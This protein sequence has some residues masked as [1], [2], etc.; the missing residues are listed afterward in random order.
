[1]TDSI[2][3][4]LV[5]SFGLLSVTLNQLETDL[6]LLSKPE[7]N[8]YPA[9]QARAAMGNKFHQFSAP[10]SILA[11]VVFEPDFPFYH[12]NEAIFERKWKDL[13]KIDSK[14]FQ[15]PVPSVI[16]VVCV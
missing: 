7:D 9:T 1:M 3:C 15:M 16:G 6:R 12:V 11:M 10:E 14:S 5:F 2:R 8:W 13:R 4:E